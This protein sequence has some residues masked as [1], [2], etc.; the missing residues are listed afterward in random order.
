[1]SMR[2][3]TQADEGTAARVH[4]HQTTLRMWAGNCSSQ[5]AMTV[6][7]E[8]NFYNMLPD[9]ELVEAAQTEVN[10]LERDNPITSCRVTVGPPDTASKH[11]PYDVRIVVLAGSKMVR[12]ECDSRWSRSAWHPWSEKAEPDASQG[13][14]HRAFAKIRFQLQRSN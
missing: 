1:M 2:E 6:P 5:G 8:V 3:I 4:R 7:L 13:A 14:L 10:S 12:V 11:S 9:P